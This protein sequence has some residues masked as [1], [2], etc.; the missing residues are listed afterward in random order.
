[1]RSNGPVNEAVAGTGPGKR[2]RISRRSLL[3]GGAS[4]LGIT[5]FSIGTATGNMPLTTAVQRALGVASTTPV[6]QPGVAKVERVFSAARNREVDLVTLLPSRNPPANLPVSLL[7]HGLHGR[8]RNAAPT[9]T[10]AEL[11][12]QVARH[13]V[14]PFGLVAVDGGDDYWHANRPGDDPMRMLLEEVPQWLSRRRLGGPGGQ[15]FACTGMSMGGFGA[16]LYAR[17]RAERAQPLRAL[18]LLAPAL[19]LSWDEMAKRGAFHDA[20]DW[21]ALDPLKHLD[22]TRSIPTGLWCG[23]EDPFI[24]GARQFIAATHPAIAYTARGRHGDTFNRTV[25]PSVIGFLG[26][27]VPA[28]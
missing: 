11:S 14:A 12:S 18:A 24:A 3:I 17:R 13:A 19:I 5:A 28:A 22:A 25:V 6:S 1:M 4:G 16:L 7:L 15:P 9:G 8:A 23:T 27:N 20:A 2:R 26:R 21:A 10:L